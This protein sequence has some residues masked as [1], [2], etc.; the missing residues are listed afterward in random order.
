MLRLFVGLFSEECWAAD[1]EELVGGV[2]GSGV[3]G[4]AGCLRVIN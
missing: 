4:V 3:V 2:E 1:L